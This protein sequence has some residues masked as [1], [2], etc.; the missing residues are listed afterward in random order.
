M[1]TG[2]TC[3]DLPTGE[4]TRM[5]TKIANA[6]IQDLDHHIVT[7][8]ADINKATLEKPKCQTLALA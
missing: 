7:T 1:V 5:Q 3:L 4:T 2:L 8:E 6:G